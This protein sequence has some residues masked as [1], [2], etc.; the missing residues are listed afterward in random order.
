MD[1]LFVRFST[2]NNQVRLVANPA[3]AVYTDDTPTQSNVS[4]SIALGVVEPTTAARAWCTFDTINL[5]WSRRVNSTTPCW[6]TAE[7]VAAT[8]TTL[9]VRRQTGS[10]DGPYYDLSDVVHLADAGELVVGHLRLDR[11]LRG[12]GRGLPA[13]RPA[14]RVAER[15]V[16]P[17]HRR[18]ELA[19][20]RPGAGQRGR[21]A[22]RTGCARHQYGP[23]VVGDNAYHALGNGGGGRPAARRALQRHRPDGGRVPALDTS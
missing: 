16:V 6:T 23:T 9:T 3:G 21:R 14:L 15:R 19:D 18:R 22:D 11:G 1:H 12:L 10:T 2:R 4:T 7:T 8:C 17:V 13:G 20:R 5:L